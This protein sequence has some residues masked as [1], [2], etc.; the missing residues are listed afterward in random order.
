MVKRCAGTPFCR[1]SFFVHHVLKARFSYA[2]ASVRRINNLVFFA[3]RGVF[4]VDFVLNANFEYADAG[5]HR[6]ETFCSVDLI[7]DARF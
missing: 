4:R 5:K 3:A 1:K 7:P 6:L 2:A